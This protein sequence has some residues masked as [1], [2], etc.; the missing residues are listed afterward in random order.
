MIE[1]ATVFALGLCLGLFLRR[2]RSDKTEI[3]PAGGE[4]ESAPVGEILE[5]CFTAPILAVAQ[6]GIDPD[7]AL[8]V[9]ALGDCDVWKTPTTL[10]FIRQGK[11]VASLEWGS[12]EIPE[13]ER[14][15][16][17]HTTGAEM[18]HTI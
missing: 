2:N 15:H 7:I 17:P 12:I 9:N 5:A 6:Y 1:A 16:M 10:I 18:K 14:L 4:S 11:P 8:R 13:I 3:P